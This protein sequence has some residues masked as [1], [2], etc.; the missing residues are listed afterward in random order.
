MMKADY[1]TTDLGRSPRLPQLRPTILATTAMWLAAFSAAGAE[2]GQ[3]AASPD[4]TLVAWAAPANLNQ[5]G[6]SVLTIQSGDRFDAIVFG[7]RVRGKWM[8]GS[9]LS[10][11]HRRT[12]TPT[13][14]RLPVPTRWSRWRSRT[15]ATKSASTATA[16]R[17]RPTKPRTW[18]C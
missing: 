15:P 7:E 13:P 6:G 18:T 17:T 12:R 16:S 2:V 4:K 9:E 3:K 11:A 1:A 10:T 14:P 8:A 5:Q